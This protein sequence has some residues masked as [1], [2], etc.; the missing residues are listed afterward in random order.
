MN[1][2]ESTLKKLIAAGLALSL[3]MPGGCGC[4]TE[5]TV[6]WD[7]AGD[8][9]DVPDS[10]DTQDDGAPSDTPA[11][12][13]R[14]VEIVESTGD[15]ICDEQDFNIHH[16]TV[17]L[18]L[19]LDQSSSMTGS[20]WGQATA[21]MEQ[22]L[23]NPAFEDMHFGLDAFPD[24]YPG[25]WSDCGVLCF[26]CQDDECGTRFP[27]QV[28]VQ[29]R[30]ISAEHIIAHMNNP[31]YPQFCTFTPL[32]NAME[33]YDTGPG[34]T[35]APDMYGD[36]G[37]NYLV[38]ISDG[39]DEGCF[40]GDPVSSL[41]AHTSN[42]LASHNIRSFAIGFGST[43]GTMASELNAIASNGGTEFD[44]FLHAEDADSLAE[45]LESIASTVIT[46]EYV[47]APVDPIADPDEVNFYVDG[48]IV[49]MDEDCTADSGEGWHWVDDEHTT[50]EFC[51]DYCAAI[52][53]GEVETIKATFGCPT[54]FI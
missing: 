9:G 33:Y 6:D 35:D 53:E 5:E 17:R 40:S 15:D 14:D 20:P 48:E 7:A 39:E 49:P 47:L 42:I 43:S 26:R 44:T 37:D 24:G 45:A 27:P 31:A 52:K 4:E 1:H 54:I 51:G 8:G 50:V 29:P 28:P 25:A 34:P 13:L 19:L 38:V 23:L 22:L 2:K 12:D 41:A 30:Y 46:C 18:M 3:L 21:A 32:V 11:D 36:D 10:S 16:E